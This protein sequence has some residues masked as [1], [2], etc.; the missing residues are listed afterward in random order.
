MSE[1]LSINIIKVFLT[2]YFL[3]I[4]LLRFILIF[5]ITITS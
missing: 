3:S 4:L 2:K 1:Y 5:I